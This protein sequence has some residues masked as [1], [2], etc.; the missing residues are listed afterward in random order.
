MSNSTLI[1]QFFPEISTKKQAKLGEFCNLVKDWNERL[2]L[3]SRKDIEKIEENHMLPS[4]T[5]AKICPFAE[6]STIMDV[7]TGGGFPGIP[8][9]ICFPESKFL[10]VDSIGK[11]IR[12]VQEM[13]THLGLSNVETF[14]GR[15]ESIPRKF[16]FVVGRA[17]TEL[18]KF[19]EW[20]HSSI[21][22]GSRSKLP[23]GVLYLKGGDVAE[24][25]KKTGIRDAQVY[26]LEQFFE[27]KYCQTKCLIYIDG[28]LLTY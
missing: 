8:L 2:N 23:N 6:G 1:Q 22:P 5:I 16:D 12:A 21:K 14:N 19:L 7:G 15:V 28:R 10:L 11:K 20:V 13:I 25:I 9:A 27:G 17:V 3:V 18:P 4:L 24:E 26:E